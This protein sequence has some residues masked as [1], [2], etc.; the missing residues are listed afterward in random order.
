MPVRKEEAFSLVELLV[1]IAIIAVIAALA[2]PSLTRAK[3]AANEASAVASVK[4]IATA[5]GVYWTTFGTG[6]AV[7]LISLGGPR[8]CF[9]PT[10]QAACIVPEQLSMWPLQK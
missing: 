6:F 3:M 8:P 2:V 4:V 5:E 1:C 7:D 10:M 9:P